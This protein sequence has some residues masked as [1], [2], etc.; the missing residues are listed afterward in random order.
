MELPENFLIKPHE[1]EVLNFKEGSIIVQP[2]DDD[3]S[4]YVVLDGL[5]SVYINVD[6]C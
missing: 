4:I 6:V 3:D 1:I 2:G 5:V